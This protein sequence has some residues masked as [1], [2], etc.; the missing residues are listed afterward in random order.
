MKAREV[1]ITGCGA[2]TAAGTGTPA[3][4][5]ALFGDRP[6]VVLGDGESPPVG[7]APELPATRRVRRLDRCARLFLA[8]ATEAWEDAGLPDT[9]PEPDRC[10]LIEGSSLGP[11]CELIEESEK[12]GA[13]MDA[14]SAGPARRGRP[15]DLVRF[16]TG[17]GGALFAQ[18]RGVAGPVLHVSCGS[19]SS[20][21]AIGEA[22]AWV[23]S[24]RADLVVAGGADSPVH[25]DVRELFRAAGI[26][27]YRDGAPAAC[28]PFDERRCGTWL[29]EGAGV[30]VLESAERARAR[31]H[32]PLAMLAG[33]GL[34]CEPNSM[35]APDPAGGGLAAAVREALGTGSL[36]S[37]APGIG[38]IKAHATGTPKGDAAECRGLAAALG[39]GFA[40]LPI[41]G[42]KPLLGHCLGASGA[43]EAVAAVLALRRAVVPATLGMERIDPDLPPCRVVTGPLSLKAPGALLLSES[44]GGRS[45]ALV[46]RAA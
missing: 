40:D 27:A 6:L 37:G 13:R 5:A 36:S 31:G 29:G 35:T 30:V 15:F 20:T 4:E 25:P 12:A 14:D 26:L 24:G 1:W 8:A 46:L 9:A 17:A 22:A 11:M 16:M 45:A 32:E 2:V 18:T 10:A 23:A 34:S 19:V 44:F 41:T 42:L 38:W 7:R 43:V 33:Y 39:P 28:L 21:S 3:L